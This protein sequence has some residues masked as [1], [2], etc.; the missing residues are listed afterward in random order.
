MYSKGLV[1]HMNFPRRENKLDFMGDLEFWESSNE[2]IKWGKG[3]EHG[4][5]QQ[6][7]RGI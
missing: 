4:E 2:E 5:R 1:R 7:L 6:E 3:R